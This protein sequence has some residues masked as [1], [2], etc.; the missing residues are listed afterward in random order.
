LKLHLYPT[1]RPMS[2]F[3]FNGMTEVNRKQP[4][5]SIMLNMCSHSVSLLV[6]WCVLHKLFLLSTRAT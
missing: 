4:T 3:L 2:M 6:M 1:L 5:G